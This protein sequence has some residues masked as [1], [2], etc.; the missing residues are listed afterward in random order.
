MVCGAGGSCECD[1]AGESRQEHRGHPSRRSTC[2]PVFEERSF[3]ARR[4]SGAG[5]RRRA[6]RKE[7]WQLAAA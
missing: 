5:R 4:R 1:Q 3:S 7:R 2:W 6:K